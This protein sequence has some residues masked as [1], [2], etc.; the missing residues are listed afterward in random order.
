ML[1]SVISALCQ[2]PGERLKSYSSSDTRQG[3][4][5]GFHGAYF[6]EVA[7][8]DREQSPVQVVGPPSFILTDK[9]VIINIEFSSEWEENM[10]KSHYY[11]S[12]ISEYMWLDVC[13]GGRFQFEY[14]EHF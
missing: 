12:K 14:A 10:V 4:W 2:N 13:G 5:G 9:E 8:K 6:G 3:Q 11:Y 1:D 7:K